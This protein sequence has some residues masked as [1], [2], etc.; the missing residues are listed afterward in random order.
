MPSQDDRD[1]SSPRRLRIPK[2]LVAALVGSSATLA[3][4]FSCDEPKPKVPVDAPTIV[5]E[6]GTI[7][8]SDIDGDMIADAMW[9]AKPDAKPDAMP[10]AKPDAQPDARPDARPDAPV[11]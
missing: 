9:D 11:V 4:S 6:E 2:A 3:V 10:D 7:D 5:D 1:P 8:A